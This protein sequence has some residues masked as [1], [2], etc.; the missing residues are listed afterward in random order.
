MH[1][2]VDWVR[3]K[4][5][6]ERSDGQGMPGK[7]HCMAVYCDPSRIAIATPGP[8]KTDM[9]ADDKLLAPIWKLAQE[10]IRNAHAIVFIG[11]RI[12]PSDAFTRAWLIEQLRANEGDRANGRGGAGL[13]WT[14][15]HTVLGANTS[16]VDSQR[17]EALLSAVMPERTR[18]FGEDPQRII[19]LPM[20]AEDFLGVVNRETLFAPGDLPGS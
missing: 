15:C 14:R 1:G 2:S 5:G 12:P 3:E 20:W 16:G 11:Y 13:P 17:L 9:I 8:T 7:Q 19:P 10:R 4:H 18:P 6:I